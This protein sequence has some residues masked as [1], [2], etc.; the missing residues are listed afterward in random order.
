MATPQCGGTTA[1]ATAQ[2]DWRTSLSDYRNQVIRT[3][4]PRRKHSARKPVLADHKR[5][6]RKLVPPFTHL[7][8]PLRE[9]SWRRQQVPEV[10]WIALVHRRF[11]DKRAVELLTTL[12]RDAREVAPGATSPIFGTTT[13]YQQL[14]RDQALHLRTDFKTPDLQNLQEALRPLVALYPE[15]PLRALFDSE[16]TPANTDV[17]LLASTTAILLDRNTREATIAQATLTWFGFDSGML[18]VAPHLTIAQFPR[19]EEYPATDFSLQLAASIRAGLT[20]FFVIPHYPP[21]PSW[22]AYFWNR[23]LQISPCKF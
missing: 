15:C 10:L 13:A 19:I 4:L 3:F 9:V 12:T 5:M 16:Q 6:G 23:G 7:I 22:P 1:R 17:E 11:G 20:M 2:G 14:S 18:Q 8:G 21:T